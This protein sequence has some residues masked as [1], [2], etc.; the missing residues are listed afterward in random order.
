MAAFLNA[1]LAEVR[2]NPEMAAMGLGG[3]LDTVTIAA[4]GTD[5]TVG[6]AIPEA[7]VNQILGFVTAM[8]AAEGFGQGAAPTPEAPPAQ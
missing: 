2:A 8:M 4:S 1:G 6:L 5:V 7:T 3:I